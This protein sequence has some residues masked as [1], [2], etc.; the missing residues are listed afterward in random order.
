VVLGHARCGGIQA[1]RSYQR[2]PARQGDRHF[3]ASWV[4]IAA[5]ALHQAG[6]PAAGEDEGARTEQEA[7]KVSLT[8]LGSFP[9]IA[10]AVD[11][12]KLRLHGWWF[13]LDHG[14]LW[15]LDP[16][17]GRFAPLA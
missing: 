2:D 11:A 5:P 8:N 15:A 3:I 6:A 16:A 14:A 1:L 10:A 17:S 13:D 9:W 12:G 7:I 4:S